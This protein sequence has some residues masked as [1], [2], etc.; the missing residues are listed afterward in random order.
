MV[1]LLHESSENGTFWV[2]EGLIV[3]S[4]ADTG[5]DHRRYRPGQSSTLTD[6]RAPPSSQ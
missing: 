2:P 3:K 6:D 5:Q 1:G 4:A